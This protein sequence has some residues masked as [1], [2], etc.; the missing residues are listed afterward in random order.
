[1]QAA[2]EHDDIAQR[3]QWHMALTVGYG[4]YDSLLFDEKPSQLFVLPRWSLYYNRL[5]VENLDLGFNLLES[6]HFSLDLSTKQSFDALLVRKGNAEDAL[7]KSIAVHDIKWPIPW[8]SDIRDTL[9]LTKRHSSY[10]AGATLYFRGGNTELRSALHADISGVHNGKEWHN[11]LRY[12]YQYGAFE[13][14]T[15]MGLRWLDRRYGNYYF[16]LRYSETED[17]AANQP[18]SMWLP[19]LKLEAS[20]TLTDDIRLVAHWKRE[21]YPS[22][23]TASVFIGKA[24][25]DVWFT[26]LQYRW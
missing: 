8:D 14:A 22:A 4:Q 7:I 12:H 10:L 18:G 1:M 24:Q 26:G 17:A 13:L 11:Q 16:G 21:W 20:F 15:S 23:I 19:S 2:D 6:R 25:H 5:Y 9:D 3:L